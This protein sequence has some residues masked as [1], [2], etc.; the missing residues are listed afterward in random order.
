MKKVCTGFL[1]FFLLSVSGIG[2]VM[3]DDSGPLAA[4]NFTATVWFT[5]D[6]IFRGVSFSDD[7]LAVQ[8]SMD[9]A[10]E[11]AYAGIWGS[12]LELTGYSSEGVVGDVVP[13]VGSSIE[14]DFYVGYT[15][16][17]GDIDYDAAL[18]YYWFPND[19]GSL[20]ADLFEAVLTLSYAF[21]YIPYSPIVS[22]S[23][24]YSPDATLEDGASTLLQCLSK[25][26][27]YG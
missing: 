11:N 22:A 3:A 23:G 19:N 8:A 6:Y 18:I 4:K 12:S 5:S 20:E 16:A 7:D 15:G 27:T 26:T 1:L 10:Y 25:S 2:G 9:W 21:A 13:T 24:A 17:F 14:Y